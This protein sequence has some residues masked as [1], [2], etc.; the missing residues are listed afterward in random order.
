MLTQSIYLIKIPIF[1]RTKIS[2]KSGIVLDFYILHLLQISLTPGIW[3][4]TVST[5]F[6][7]QFVVIYIFNFN[8]IVW[9]HQNLFSYYPW[10]GH[11][12]CFWFCVFVFETINN[13]VINIFMHIFKRIR[14][15]IFQNLLIYQKP[16]V[17]QVFPHMLSHWTPWYATR[18]LG[19]DSFAPDY[20]FSYRPGR[21]RQDFWFNLC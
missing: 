5:S 20:N 19:S 12:L 4:I 1:S 17:N 8:S 6:F 15:K 11:L 2:I 16:S 3:K 14:Q 7:I 21:Q 10:D 13:A 18:M 9:I